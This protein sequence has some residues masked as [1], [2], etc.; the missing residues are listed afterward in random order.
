M[1][2]SS[3][4]ASRRS[5]LLAV[6]LAA[7]LLGISQ[8]GTAA[9]I[10]QLTDPFTDVLI[11][12]DDLGDEEEV[13]DQHLL[14]SPIG[15]AFRDE[16]SQFGSPMGGAPGETGDD[17]TSS[18]NGLEAEDGQAIFVL[19]ESPLTK[20]G[21]YV[22]S[23]IDDGGGIVVLEIFSALGDSL[24]SVSLPALDD[25]EFQFLGLMSDM[26]FTVAM[27]SVQPE[28]GYGEDDL[29]L[30]IEDLQVI[31]EPATAV[32]LVGALTALAVWR[33]RVR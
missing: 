23:E 16:L 11:D 20:V 2:I 19:F 22:A 32:L 24:G 6:G 30:V 13:D 28:M 17:Y 1:R 4:L 26:P 27:F 7:V 12:F 14:L 9:T 31:P 3:S 18:P 8:V 10:M 5:E 21:A 33:R 25:D 15:V 29:E